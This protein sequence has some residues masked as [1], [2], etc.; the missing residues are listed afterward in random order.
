MG[1]IWGEVTARNRVS[2]L[3]AWDL[4]A[5]GPTAA[6]QPRTS[7]TDLRGKPTIVFAWLYV[8]CDRA[9]PGFRL[10]GAG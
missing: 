5:S 3:A 1:I 8:E 4:P 2:D 10:D 7:L 9:P 6:I